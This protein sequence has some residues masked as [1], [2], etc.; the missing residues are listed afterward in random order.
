M[1]QWRID[2][3][4]YQEV[5]IPAWKAECIEI[6][7]AWATAKQLGQ[8]G[9]RPP[10]PPKPKRPLKPK[11]PKSMSASAL[12]DL[13]TVIRLTGIPEEGEDI[14]EQDNASTGGETDHEG[15]E[16]DEDLINS[17]RALE[18]GHF[19]QVSLT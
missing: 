11:Q 6:D 13:S 4:Q 2:I 12:G 5:I 8:R 10:Y 19:A 9:K 14:L 7:T 16:A 3:Q 18:I 17:M 15:H 1:K